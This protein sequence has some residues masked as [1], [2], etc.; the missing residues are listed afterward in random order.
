MSFSQWATCSAPPM[1]VAALDRKITAPTATPPVDRI[2]NPRRTIGFRFRSCMSARR[3]MT[4]PGATSLSLRSASRNSLIS[5]DRFAY[6]SFALTWR[7]ALSPFSPAPI[8]LSVPSQRLRGY[9]PLPVVRAADRQ[10]V[11]LAEVA[12]REQRRPQVDPRRELRRRDD[13]EVDPLA[14]GPEIDWDRDVALAPQD[15]NGDVS[16]CVAVDRRH[17]RPPPAGRLRGT[18]RS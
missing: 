5:R 13:G 15:G 12:G 18:S 2:A 3:R 10:V 11:R 1:A 6:A 7:L 14:A 17:V 16:G 9:V 8:C 4:A